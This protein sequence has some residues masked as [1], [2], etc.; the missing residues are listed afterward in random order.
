[1]KIFSPSR[2]GNQIDA[3]DLCYEELHFVPTFPVV[4]AR[5]KWGNKFNNL[6]L[7]CVH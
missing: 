2:V 7:K 1:M 5:H 3:T 4:P 6:L